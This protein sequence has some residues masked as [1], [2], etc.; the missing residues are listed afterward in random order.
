MNNTGTKVKAKVIVYS[1]YI[2]MQKSS[3]I[4]TADSSKKV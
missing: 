1:V 2:H 4:C 3:L